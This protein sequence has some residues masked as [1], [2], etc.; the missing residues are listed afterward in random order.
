M[1][2]YLDSCLIKEE[3]CSALVEFT[4]EFIINLFEPWTNIWHDWLNSQYSPKTHSEDEIGWGWNIDKFLREFLLFRLSCSVDDSLSS[5]HVIFFFLLI[6]PQSILSISP[7]STYTHPND[8]NQSQNHQRM[9]HNK[10]GLLFIL[11]IGWNKR[12][13]DS[14][15]CV[16]HHLHKR[17][18][19]VL[20]Y[21]PKNETVWIFWMNRTKSVESDGWYEY[22]FFASID[23]MSARNDR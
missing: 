20:S 19:S 1:Y 17:K 8:N 3:W 11:V 7:P 18:Y 23:W 12:K 14:S 21:P 22:I 13:V 16:D 15:I 2:T 4:M 10:N 6:I 9:K 5:T